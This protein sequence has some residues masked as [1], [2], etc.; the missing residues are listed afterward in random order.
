[1]YCYIMYTFHRPP[2]GD[3]ENKQ[4]VTFRSP[5]SQAAAVPFPSHPWIELSPYPV[6]PYPEH[7]LHITCVW[8][9]FPQ[10]VN[11]HMF[12]CKRCPARG[13]ALCGLTYIH[14]YIYIHTCIYIYMY[15][16]M[17]AY[18]YTHICTYIYIYTHTYICVYIYIYI[19]IYTY[20]YT[21]IHTYTYVDVRHPTSE[22]LARLRLGRRSRLRLHR[23]HGDGLAEPGPRP[24]TKCYYIL[25]M[26]YLY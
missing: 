10:H 3:P 6:G 11:T 7:L 24:R 26:S 14:I 22:T 2:K 21:Y 9:P 15:M 20:V 16:C 19:Y 1:M 25:R 12:D 8:P 13:R 18:T 4:T 17:Y 23:R 5:A